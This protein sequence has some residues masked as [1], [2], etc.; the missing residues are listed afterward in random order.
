MSNLWNES[1]EA[2]I[3]DQGGDFSRQFVLDDVMLK[4]VANGD[5]RSPRW[6]AS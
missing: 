2:W 4:R 6:C 3:K 1:A 5:G